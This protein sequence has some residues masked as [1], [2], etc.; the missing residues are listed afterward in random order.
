MKIGK[1]FHLIASVISLVTTAAMFLPIASIKGAVN[2]FKSA[3]G[4]DCSATWSNTVILIGQAIMIILAIF[5]FI[6]KGKD[7]I[8]YQKVKGLRIIQISLSFILM[9]LSFLTLTIIG[10]PS[11]TNITIGPGP[12]MY[13]V[14]NILIIIFL[15]LSF[16][17]VA[18]TDE[19]KLVPD[20]DKKSS[21]KS[22]IEKLDLLLKYKQLYDAK[23][24]SK[25][26]YEEK[27]KELLND[28]K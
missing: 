22:E 8:H 18:K 27:K 13:G 9:L 6:L 20:V 25:K 15:I 17:Y 21:D 11:G 10:V 19:V 23:A 12:I 4:I 28:G 2:M 5:M 14:F 3:L 24:I 1:T 26:E 16:I 7:Y